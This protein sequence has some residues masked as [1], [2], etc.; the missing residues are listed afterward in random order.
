MDNAEEIKKI[1]LQL[2]DNK[3][4]IEIWLNAYFMVSF[5]S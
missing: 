5:N 4:K 1:L 2:R 3:E